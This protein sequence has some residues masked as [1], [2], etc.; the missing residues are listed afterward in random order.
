MENRSYGI[1]EEDGF[2]SN[3]RSMQQY[4][5]MTADGK[6]WWDRDRADAECIALM[7][8][9]LSELLEALR[10][11][12]PPD[13]HLPAF[14]SAEV[15]AADVVIRMMDWAEHRGLRLAEAIAAKAAFNRDRPYRHGGKAF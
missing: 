1:V 6:G 3:F 5:A 12:N 9:E 4:V 11:S 2:V 7:H 15:E 14:S 13:K 10:E 8:S